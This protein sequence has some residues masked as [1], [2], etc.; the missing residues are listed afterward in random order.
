MAD[1]QHNMTDKQVKRLVR[2]ASNFSVAVKSLDPDKQKAYLDRQR[3]VAET[4]RRAQTNDRLLR[5]RLK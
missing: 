5:L 1:E 2:M 3:E 4:R